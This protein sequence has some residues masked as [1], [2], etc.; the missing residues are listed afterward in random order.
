MNEEHIKK[1][2][3]EVEKIFDQTGDDV[4]SVSFGYKKKSGEFTGEKSIRFG[5]I[6]KK[7]INEIPPEKLLPYSITIDGVEYKTDVFQIKNVS[8]GIERIYGEVLTSVS[9]S[10][11]SSLSGSIFEI[12]KN[13]SEEIGVSAASFDNCKS[14]TLVT[15]TPGAT[16][17]GMLLTNL[18]GAR[19]ASGNFAD[20]TD[21]CFDNAFTPPAAGPGY[22][23]VYN[24]PY[25]NYL[26]GRCYVRYTCNYALSAPRIDHTQKK[27][28]LVGGISM[29]N[30]QVDGQGWV[31]T[32]GGIVKDATDNKMV[33]ITNTHVSGTPSY[34]KNGS[35]LPLFF[36]NDS[37]AE[38]A[39]Y[40]TG[41]QNTQPSNGDVYP[42]N[43]VANDAIGTTKRM[44]PLTSTG[45]NYIDCAIINLTA[46]LVSTDSWK[47]LNLGDITSAPPFATTAE[48]DSITVS[49]PLASA[50]RTSGARGTYVT[51]ST[52]LPEGAGYLDKTFTPCGFIA[53]STSTSILV[54]GYTPSGNLT[55][56]DVI[57]L[58]FAHPYCITP[59]IGGD[60]GS[61][62]FGYIGGQWKIIGLIFAG[63]SAEYGF[64]C[65]IDRVAN[66]MKLQAYTGDSVDAN[67]N[68]PTYVTLSLATYGSEASASID[69]KTY[70]QLGKA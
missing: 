53:T 22:S 34:L 25:N 26:S 51:Q 30:R 54:S 65:R 7:P 12:S 62:L 21:F 59:V 42:Y 8:I 44:F 1:V 47:Q 10:I 63:D 55:F 50:G 28:A 23:W 46:S 29:I 13:G 39:S 56:G 64:A 57:Q 36:S 69:G 70:W 6:E 48:I 16:I 15:D 61:L 45:T 35:H 41:I 18:C 27:R 9:E 32:L 40:Y 33:G 37:Y 20:G 14:Y 2:K 19:S 38:S 43:Y 58:E 3:E 11:I 24:D 31:G 4:L 66:L 68:V 5:V 17:S 52:A 49:T 60:S 67:P